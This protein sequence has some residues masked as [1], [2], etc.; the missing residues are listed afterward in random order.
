MLSFI[1][2]GMK[3]EADSGSFEWEFSTRCSQKHF[4]IGFQCSEDGGSFVSSSLSII[5][6]FCVTSDPM[7]QK[8]L[9]DLIIFHLYA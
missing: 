4:S 7:I 3:N 2:Y 8:K 9:W 6:L 1:S 5:I